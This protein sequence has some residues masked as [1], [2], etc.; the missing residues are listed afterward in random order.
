MFIQT[1]VPYIPTFLSFREYPPLSLAYNALSYTPDLCFVDAHGKAHPRMLGAAS[2]F[3]IL[4]DTPTI[5]VAKSYLCGTIQSN[6]KSFDT[7]I[8]NGEVVG[9]RFVSKPGC[10]P[11]YIS[12]GHRV[13][14]STAVELTRK[15]IIKYR[16]PEPIRFAHKIATESRQTLKQK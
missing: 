9:A 13:S 10:K 14:L 15:C 1:Q 12:T 16:L 2:H 3:G 7:I 4:R 6:P 5:G 8:L 11:I